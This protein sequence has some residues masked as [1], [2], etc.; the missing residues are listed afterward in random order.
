MTS[1]GQR[2]RATQDRVVN[3]FTKV[4][5]WTT[6]A[7]GRTAATA[8]WSPICLAPYLSDH[9]APE[10]V[11]KAIHELQRVAGDQCATCTR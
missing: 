3:L 1:I 11:T 2:E 9:Y 6:S 4:L 7:T 8:T 5:K 10:L